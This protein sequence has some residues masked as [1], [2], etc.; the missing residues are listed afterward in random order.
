MSS[1]EI[2][3]ARLEDQIKYYDKSSITN[4]RIYEC[5][6]IIEFIS[7]AA[8]PVLASKAVPPLVL[9]ILG[10]L[11]VVLEGLQQLKQFNNNWTN[12]RST[13]E[14]LRHEKYLFE[15][16]ADCYASADNPDTLLAE[17]IESLISREHAKW[18]STKEEMKKE[19]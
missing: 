6:K 5:L 2:T 8:I 7:A 9:G 11:I 19:R 10:S 17:R 1:L 3:M 12:Y 18:V 14:S 4:K 16:K 13:C 15:A